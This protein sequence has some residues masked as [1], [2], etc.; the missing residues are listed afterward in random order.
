MYFCL[1][2][3]LGCISI[4]LDFVGVF[5]IIILNSYFKNKNGINIKDKK[6]INLLKGYFSCKYLILLI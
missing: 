3:D 1:L 6:L 5:K 4:G 2:I